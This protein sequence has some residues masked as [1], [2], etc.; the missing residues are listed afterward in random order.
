MPNGLGDVFNVEERMMIPCLMIAKLWV[1]LNWQPSQKSNYYIFI[2]LIVLALQT[3]DRLK[4]FAVFNQQ[5][6]QFEAVSQCLPDKS[7]FIS[8]D[9]DNIAQ[10]PMQRSVRHPFLTNFRFSPFL[11][12]PGTIFAGRDIV[13]ASNYEA[14]SICPYFA[15]K[16]QPWLDKIIGSLDIGSRANLEYSE[17]LLGDV[18]RDLKSTIIPVNYLMTSSFIA[19]SENGVPTKA[20]LSTISKN[21]NLL[22]TSPSGTVRIYRRL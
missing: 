20:V 22:C 1:A 13:D 10:K 16:F 12:F 4:A 14:L 21:Y 5:A 3:T 9:L 8:L 7:A 6:E 18:V 17:G 15:L 11:H 2:I 19:G